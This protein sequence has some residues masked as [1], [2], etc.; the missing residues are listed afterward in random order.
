TN[1]LANTFTATSTLSSANFTAGVSTTIRIK[2]TQYNYVYDEVEVM[3]G[4]GESIIN[5][6]VADTGNNRIMKRTISDLSYVSKIGSS[7]S[8]DDQFSSPTKIALDQDNIFVMDMANY[9]VVKRLKNDT[10]DFVSKVGSFGTNANQF[11][12]MTDIVV[13]DQYFYVLDAQRI[14]KFDKETMSQVSVTANIYGSSGSLCADET[15]LY[16]LDSGSGSLLKRVLKSNLSFVDSI[17][18]GS[19]GTATDEGYSITCDNTYIYIALDTTTNIHKIL[20]LLKSNLSFVSENLYNNGLLT[21]QMGTLKQIACDETYIFIG[22]NVY[23]DG[24]QI[25]INKYLKTNMSY[26]SRVGGVAGNGNDQFS[27]GVGFAVEPNIFD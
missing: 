16:L 11:S 23:S 19:L 25:F 7:G 6:F 20:K 13:D 26:V 12:N 27:T 9:R 4:S 1:T 17:N 24:W 3:V 2:S 22:N 8:G 14:R 5:F 10:I 15:Y 21:S 18:I